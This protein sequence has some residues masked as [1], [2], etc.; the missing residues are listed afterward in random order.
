MF[1]LH[2]RAFPDIQKL[3]CSLGY[4]IGTLSLDNTAGGHVFNKLTDVVQFLFNSMGPDVPV[5]STVEL[6]WWG[7]GVPF[8]GRMSLAIFFRLA[9]LPSQGDKR[10]SGF[11]IGLLADMPEKEGLRQFGEAL[12]AQLDAVITQ[13]ATA[14]NGT[15]GIDM[16]LISGDNAHTMSVFNV[17]VFPVLCFISFLLMC[18]HLC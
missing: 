16:V 3:A 8:G 9:I 11:W 15:P 7:D 18:L 4:P 14:Q 5:D 12:G 10:L 6:V 17:S 2:I 13:Y 1:P